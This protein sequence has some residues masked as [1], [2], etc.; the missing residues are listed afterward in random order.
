MTTFTLGAPKFLK[1]LGVFFL[2]LCIGTSYAQLSTHGTP[3]SFNTN[4]SRANIPEI[5][6][7]VIDLVAVRAEDAIR[8]QQ[9]V[10]YRFAIP[11]KVNHNL[12]NS[13][14]WRTLPN[15]DRLWRLKITC[16]GAISTNFLYS[17]FYMPPGATFYIYSPD[18]THVLGGYTTRNN[19]ASRLFATEILDS[20]SAIL[21][22]YEPATVAGQG[23]IQIAQ[24]SYGYRG[25]P[26]IHYNDKEDGS[27]N[28]NA[29]GVCQVNVNCSPEGDNWQTEKK[30]VARMIINGSG[31]CSGTLINNTAD[32]CEPYF[33][34]AEHCIDS[35]YDAISNPN[36]NIVFYWNFERPNCANSGD[37]P[38]DTTSGATLVAN[39][40]AG[41]NYS[42]ASDFALFRLDENPA[43]SYDVYFAGFD[44][45]GNTGT[46]GVGIHHP[47]GDAKK[48][49][50]HSSI[51]GSVVTDRFW[52]IYWDATDN[53]HSVTEGGSS[54]S[55]LFR[56]NGRLIGQLFGGFDGG[57]PNCSDP[58]ADEGDYGKL[59]Y[60]W[61]NNGA[62][63]ARRRVR[64]WLDPLGGGTN[65]TMDGKIPT[66]CPDIGTCSRPANISCGGS[67]SADTANGDDVFDT[68]NGDNNWTGNEFIFA[69][70][71]NVTDVIT[72]DLTNTGTADLG[73]FLLSDCD[74]ATEIASSNTGGAGADE[75][76]M[77]ALTAGVNYYI[78]IDGRDNAT[79]AFDL[80]ITCPPPPTTC[81]F[82]RVLNCGDNKADTNVGSRTDFS[83]YTGATYSYT[84]PE[85]VYEIVAGPGALTITMTWAN[86]GEDLDLLLRDICEPGSGSTLD[87]STTTGT[88]ESVTTTVPAGG[89]VYY[90]FVE[91]YAGGQ[92]PYNLSVTCS[93]VVISPKVYLQNA[94]TGP[95]MSTY[96]SI[97]NLVPTSEPYT[98]LGYNFVGGGGETSSLATISTN[99]ITDWVVV[100]LRDASD[101]TMIVASK[102][103][104]VRKDGT[105]VNRLDGAS[106]I[107]FPLAGGS[108]YYV[109]I[110]HRNHL[111][112]MTNTTVGF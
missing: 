101:P 73:L 7:D 51:P 8:D 48:I 75:Q 40:N 1:L 27:E 2:C 83:S 41:G 59:S 72:I 44:A 87:E 61:N 3:Y 90:L 25:L 94:Y 105:V 103:G 21:E 20:E 30:A 70:S 79:A 104:L 60:S 35:S 92:S 78:M 84:G 47:A 46:G 98:G 11:F 89:G 5:T 17:D 29:S 95:D 26:P 112:I 67:S 10:P 57:Q 55:G 24:I 77:I 68:H 19:R 28:L 18:N 37:V 97:N 63:D 80:T 50:T 45:S 88:T 107:G 58:A 6:T 36:A 54:G 56:S 100:E 43:D 93:S 23:V 4:L 32:N 91:G 96:L 34:T 31:L 13:G 39:S 102:A 76:I 85:N 42:S 9:N 49:A 110:K 65:T 64:D 99:D 53:G 15:G 108:S 86:G 12:E 81:D 82:Q 71:P 22:Y 52:R 14:V 109:A 33:L 69:F 111:S 62:T 74:P 16:P 106:P 66:A 38:D